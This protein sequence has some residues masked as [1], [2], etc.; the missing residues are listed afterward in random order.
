MGPWA[1]AALLLLLRA[2]RCSCRSR[3]SAGADELQFSLKKSSVV[4][5]VIGEVPRLAAR[6]T[7]PGGAVVRLGNVLKPE[8][9]AVEP[10]VAFS[11]KPGRW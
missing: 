2:P 6:V 3:Y 11:T 4:P 8:R 10:K 7:Y 1:V 5:D 9:T